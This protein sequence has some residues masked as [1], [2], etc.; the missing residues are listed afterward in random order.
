MNC[1]HVAILLFLWSTQ[2]YS[3]TNESPIKSVSYSVAFLNDIRIETLKA[4]GKTYEIW[5]KEPGSNFA[6][7]KSYGIT[8]TAFFVSDTISLYIVTAEHVAKEM[9]PN[10]DIVINGESDKPMVYKLR[11]LA[12]R[13][14][15]LKWTSNSYADVA[16]LLLDNNSK[17]FQHPYFVPIPID[18]IESERVPIR[19]REVTT[20]GFPLGLGY[21]KHF[22]PISKVSKPSSGLIEL[23][24]FDNGVISTFFLLDDPSISG[25]SG[26]PVFELPTQLVAGKEP[27]FVNV[28]RL[29]GLVHGSIADKTGGGFAAIVPS[30]Y[31]IETLKLSPKYTGILRWYHING[32]LWSERNYKDGR[33]WSVLNNFDKDGNQVENGTL[34]DGKGS[35]YIYD[36]NGKLVQIENYEDGVLVRMDKK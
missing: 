15:S 14:D 16:T 12:F 17:I 18:I 27:V 21:E 11:D 26:S 30:R 1:R 9:T 36:E 29:M 32:K 31:I 5:L 23:P 28:Y 33:P 22:S 8:G 2:L 35:I 19:E 6:K 3:Q 20:V 24:R 13:K 7:P 25:F 10:S 34:K 4:D